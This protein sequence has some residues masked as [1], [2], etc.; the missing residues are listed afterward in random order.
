MVNNKNFIHEIIGTLNKEKMRKL[1][2]VYLSFGFISISSL[3]LIQVINYLRNTLKLNFDVIVLLEDFLPIYIY[4]VQSEIVNKFKEYRVIILKSL[5]FKHIIFSSDFIFSCKFHRILGDIARK[6]SYGK[7]KR[8]L[9]PQKRMNATV[10]DI[11]HLL[12]ELSEITYLRPNAIISGLENR[13]SLLLSREL[14][15]SPEVL[16]L[17]EMFPSLTGERKSSSTNKNSTIFLHESKEKIEEKMKNA[18][19]KFITAVA[20]ILG[21]DPKM[22]IC[23]RKLIEILAPYREAVSH[24]NL[25]QLER[26]LAV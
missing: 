15:G 25:K 14:T 22:H 7:F 26:Y 20:K 12:F 16:I 21:V 10:L 13:N 19:R 18:S 11:Y 2:V 4:N 24:L 8:G 23:T 6:V 3:L 9:P 5:G 17:L 1:Y